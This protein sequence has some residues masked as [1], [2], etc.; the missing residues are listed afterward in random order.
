MW[1][2][3][4]ASYIIDLYLVGELIV[5]RFSDDPAVA[6]PGLQP[7]R[8]GDVFNEKARAMVGLVLSVPLLETV[9]GF[10]LLTLGING[11][12]MPRNAESVLC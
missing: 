7:A 12:G 11:K 1:S 6:L 3:G 2:G 5:T 10:L 8:Y 4:Q 9:M